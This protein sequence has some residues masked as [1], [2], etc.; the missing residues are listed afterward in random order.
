VLRAA[1]EAT[2]GRKAPAARL[3][4]VSRPGLDGKLARHGIDAA[5]IRARIGRG[6]RR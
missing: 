2:G 4:G 5:E 1:L 6:G 3:L